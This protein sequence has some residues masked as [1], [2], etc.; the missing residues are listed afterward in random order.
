MQR[1]NFIKKRNGLV[2]FILIDILVKKRV[3]WQYRFVF[4]SDI[5][6]TI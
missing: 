2:V 4:F 5:L 1:S 6:Q 3:N